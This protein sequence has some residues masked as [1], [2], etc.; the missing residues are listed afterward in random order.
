MLIV[1]EG[2]DK[3]PDIIKE[4][5]NTSRKHDIMREKKL[6][7]LIEGSAKVRLIPC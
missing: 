2:F 4:K 1:E 6:E 3:S 7:T 5:I